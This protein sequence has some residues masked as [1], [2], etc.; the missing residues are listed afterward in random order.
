MRN[1][2]KVIRMLARDILSRPVVSVRPETSLREAIA[3]LT[4][5][6][7]AALP[8]IDDTDRIVGVLSESDALAA[9]PRLDTA[10]VAAV[11]T[12]PV[13]VVSPHTDVSAIASTMLAEHLHSMPVAEAGVL[14]GIVARRDLLRTLI[15]DDATTEAKIRVL[16]DDYAG[17]RRDWRIKVVGNRAS[18]RG[19]FADPLEERVI[20]SLVRTVDGIDHVDIAADT[21]TY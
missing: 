12:T 21:P 15:R 14:V 2:E 9:V 1:P 18:V 16:L 3:L 13:Q 5:C 8:V 10:I 6:G 17:S 7:F 20:A 11:M 4:Q 19:R